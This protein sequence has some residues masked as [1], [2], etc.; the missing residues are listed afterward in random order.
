MLNLDNAKTFIIFSLYIND[1]KTFYWIKTFNFN[2]FKSINNCF[3]RKRINFVYE[4]FYPFYAYDTVLR[5]ETA[6]DLQIH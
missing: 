6:Y 4:A 1:L 2:F 3:N 5:A